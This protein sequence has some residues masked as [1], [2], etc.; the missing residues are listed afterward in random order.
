MKQILS[1]IAAIVALAAMP[2]LAGKRIEMQST[3]LANNQVTPIAM[4]VDADRLRVD[5]GNTSIIFLTKGG[6]RML[7]VD[8]SR[9]EYREMTQADAELLGQQVSGMMTEIQ[10]MMKNMP[11]EQRA[12]ME[13]MMKGKMG[14][15]TVA[16]PIATTYTAKGSATVNGFRCTNYD[17]LRGKEK[18]AEVC[19]AQPSDIK[20]APADFQV[21]EKM[22]D[23]FSGLVGAVQNSPLA[24]MVPVGTLTDKGLN[25]FP[26]QS[27]HF[28]SGKASSR[29]EL[30]SIDDVAV[31]DADFSTGNAKKV[32]LGIIGGR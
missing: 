29:D 25:G 27:T 18:V 22:R 31:S 8:K 15:A 24:S 14:Q 6:N 12:Q 19:A 2:L 10:G 9:N 21:V 20:I 30:K 32:E 23:M 1:A 11:P 4:L 13:A 26:V 7:I 28:V 5:Q 17:G 16:A 3:D